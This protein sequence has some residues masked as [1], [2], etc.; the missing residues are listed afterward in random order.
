MPTPT[1]TPLANITL[2]SSASSVTFST[3]PATYRDLVLVVN[4]SANGT[5]PIRARVNGDTGANYSRQVMRGIA[6]TASAL[7]G[8][9]SEFVFSS[10]VSINERFLFSIQFMDYSATNKHKTVLSRANAEGQVDA[11]ASRWANTSAI[12]SIQIYV[13]GNEMNSGTSLALYGIVA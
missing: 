13:S 11:R 10:S 12:T 4:G 6:G 9:G 7:V 3:I 8:T 2:G 1:Y 5:D